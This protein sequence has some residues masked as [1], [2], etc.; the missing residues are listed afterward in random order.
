M[1][2]PLS[3]SDYR[4]LLA[5]ALENASEADTRPP[6]EHTL[7]MPDSHRSALYVDNTVVQ[8]GRGVGKTFWYRSLLMAPLREHAA[9]E[10]R[11]N[12]LRHLRVAPGY[13]MTLDREHYPSALMLR[14]LVRTGAEPYDIWYAVLLV[15]LGQIELCALPEWPERVAWVAANP[16]EAQRTVEQADERAGEEN[17]VHLLLFDALEHLHA[18][19]SE[20]DRLAA[21]ILQL[22][23]H[24]RFGTR[25]IRFKV[26]IRPDLLDGAKFY[27]PDASKLVA[28][29]AAR[30]EWTR[31]DLYGLLFHY[32]GNQ[33]GEL[34]AR[35]RGV[36]GGWGEGPRYVP[37]LALRNDDAHQEAQF[38]QIADPFMGANFRKGKPYTWLPN[39]LMDSREQ[40]SPR[41]FLHALAKAA[42]GTGAR[43]PDHGRALHHDAIRE[44]VQAAS[45]VRVTEISEDTPWVRLA[46]EPL[47]GC[48]V[49][50][51]DWKVIDLWQAA[52]L[53]EALH[54]EAARYA[55]LDEPALVHTGPRHPDDLPRLVE[56]LDRLGVMLRRSDKRLDLP[57][58]YRIAFGLGRRGGVPRTTR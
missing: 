19:R 31:T 57:D 28:G 41:I 8:G 35:F 5:D 39:H 46:I 6:T 29:N 33:E 10:Y 40:V 49:P 47:R 12:R 38:E 52:G 26:F 36:T 25:N 55:Q 42:A 2:E 54:E 58:V 7:Y 15:S 56:E 24:M 23:L 17:L 14:E 27:F 43:H 53:S 4:Q 3:A 13:G 51:E 21:G 9:V 34:G 22:A 32:L 11:I 48:Q 37:P 18:D 45:G 1:T 16:G 20:N 50:I 30:L 44:G